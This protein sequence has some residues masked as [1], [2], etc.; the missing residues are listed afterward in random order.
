MYEVKGFGKAVQFLPRSRPFDKNWQTNIRWREYGD[1]SA[2]YLNCTAQTNRQQRLILSMQHLTTD[3]LLHTEEDVTDTAL[4]FY[5]QLYTFDSIDNES[6][7]YTVAP[8]VNFTPVN[9][10]S[11][12]LS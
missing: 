8:P 5:Q 10:Q 11:S 4:T 9:F 2:V 6:L 1:I 12:L 7:Q 3:N